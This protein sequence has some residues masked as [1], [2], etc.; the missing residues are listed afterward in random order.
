MIRSG[1]E[2][3]V[4]APRI[5]Q[6]GN[7]MIPSRT[8]RRPPA[9][10]AARL[11]PVT[12]AT[13]LVSLLFCFTGCGGTSGNDSHDPTGLTA[14]D[15]WPGEK[16]GSLTPVRQGCDILA[17]PAAPGGHFVFTLTE[18][19]LSGHAPVPHNGSERVVFAQLYETLVNVD[20]SGEVRPGLAESWTSSADGLFWTLTL[21]EGA[22]FWDGSL[23]TASDLYQALLPILD[24]R[25][26]VLDERRLSFGIADPHGRFLQMLAHPSLA[27]SVSRPGWTWPVGSGPCRL[28]ASDPPPLPDLTCL[29]NQNHPDWPTW[30]SLTF[31]VLPDTDPRDLVATDMDLTLVRDTDA[32]G[33]FDEAPSFGTVPLPWNRL[34]LLV[35]PPE[36][37]PGGADRWIQASS[38]LDA[39]RDVTAVS[40]RAWPEIVFPAGGSDFCP[41]L[42]G[43]VA[44]V[45]SARLDW[46]LAAK[47]L[48]QFVLVYPDDDP[49]AREL[50]HRLGALAGRPVRT[51]ALPSD[52][53]DFALQWQMAGAF[54]L[55]FDQQYPTGCQ[56]MATL[57]GK[58]SWLQK[59]AVGFG[60]PSSESLAGADQ[61]ASLPTRTPSEALVQQNLV[62]PLGLSRSWLVV[63][64]SLA[65]LELTFDGIPL[66]AGLG[67]SAEATPGEA[68]P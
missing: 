16:S 5:S 45:G 42:Y 38:E 40:A 65:G 10:G 23:I 31:R 7:P 62:R 55:P 59:A 32:A 19:V 54:V 21:R 24:A 22:R 28:R 29:P 3:P 53:V 64:G 33:F 48:D 43:Q 44:P 49:G 25:V 18:S 39:D 26:E 61:V 63:R 37:N 60:D 46:N 47:K 13:A 66:L 15:L 41:G 36:M 6:E 2:G 57:L 12:V 52:G 58:A 27:I 56:Q 17:G 67:T 1:N 34:Y 50:A 11:R 14:D 9:K 4:S 51:A 68:T 30:K 35:C 20:C 8:F